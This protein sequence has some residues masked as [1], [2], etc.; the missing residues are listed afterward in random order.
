VVN[1]DKFGKSVNL[2]EIKKKG[3]RISVAYQPKAA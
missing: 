2:E 3:G 1:L